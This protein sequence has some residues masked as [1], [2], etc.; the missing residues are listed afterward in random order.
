[1]DAGAIKAAVATPTLVTAFSVVVVK[2]I[3]IVL[4]DSTSAL[5][6]SMSRSLAVPSKLSPTTA[7]GTSSTSSTV[8][9][10]TTPTLPLAEPG[11]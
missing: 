11:L 10:S 5:P 3:L 7:S 1:M 9:L 8:G 4:V 2:T 6:S